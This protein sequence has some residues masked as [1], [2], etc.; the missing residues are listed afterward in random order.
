MVSLTPAELTNLVKEAVISILL[1]HG[2][3][4]E[5]LLAEFQQ[6]LTNAMREIIPPND[7]AETEFLN[8]TEAAEFLG[9]SRT[10]INKYKKVVINGKPVLAFGGVGRIKKISVAECRRVMAA[11]IINVRSTPPGKMRKQ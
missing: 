8:A 5:K 4:K 11:N 10:T 3:T 2:L 9:I 7:P 6:M 1:V